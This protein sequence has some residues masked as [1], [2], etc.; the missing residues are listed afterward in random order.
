MEQ[1]ATSNVFARSST[2][3]AAIDLAETWSRRIYIA[4]KKIDSFIKKNEIEEFSLF[5]VPDCIERTTCFIHHWLVK[6]CST[7]VCK[8][9]D[10]RY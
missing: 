4:S 2:Y 6:I 1:V 5:D 3:C 10:Y 8:F 7:S 9:V